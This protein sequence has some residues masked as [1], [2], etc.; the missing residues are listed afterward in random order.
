MTMMLSVLTSVI[1]DVDAS[2]MPAID[3]GIGF[4]LG[5]IISVLLVVS[6]LC[7]GFAIL[8]YVLMS[9]GLYK[10][11]SRRQIRNS[12]L[13]WIP[14]G[15][16]WIL[17]SISDQ[18]R[19]VAKGQVK[20]RRKV[21]L[22]LNI[23]IIVLTVVSGAILVVGSIIAGLSQRPDMVAGQFGLVFLLGAAVWVITILEIV[24]LFI[25]YYDLYRSCN[26]EKADLFLVLSILFSFTIPFFVFAVR[27]KDLGMP[28]R[29]QTPAPIAVPEAVEET[30]EEE[31]APPVEE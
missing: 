18:Y 12:W 30:V 16:V 3:E 4:A 8:S 21:L 23:A 6:L 15:N 13:A 20:N 28:P 26:P 19:Y 2:I 31:P 27:N 1:P 17:G 11:A 24:F 10:V 25:A 22:G 7:F 5:I 14:V 9:L 29:K